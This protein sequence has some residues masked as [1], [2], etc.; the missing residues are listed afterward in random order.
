MIDDIKPGQENSETSLDDKPVA[1]RRRFTKVGLGGGAVLMSLLSRPALGN[2]VECTASILAS[3]DAGTSLH[4]GL[5]C[6]DK[7]GCSADYWCSA[8]ASLEAWQRIL[9]LTGVTPDTSFASIFSCGPWTTE[10]D[11]SPMLL[12]SLL[13]G[14][15][16]DIQV[17]AARQAIAAWLNATILNATDQ[18]NLFGLTAGYI[19]AEYCNAYQSWIAS[20]MTNNAALYDLHTSLVTWNTKSCP[21]NNDPDNFFYQ[22]LGT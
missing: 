20:D 8:D 4:G 14:T 10:T 17:Q 16:T 6:Q 3:I 18:G 1:S 22:Q 21:L 5:D 7:V 13:C 9:F 19:V 15:L 12:S 11:G 2:G